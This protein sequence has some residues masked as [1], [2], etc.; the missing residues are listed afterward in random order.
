MTESE[1]K[2]GD[3]VIMY[4]NG[5]PIRGR[6]VKR[7]MKRFI[8]LND[9]SKWDLAGHPYPMMAWSTKMIRPATPERV[10]ELKRR[11]VVARIAGM[12]FKEWDALS[13]DQLDR[14]NSILKESS[15][16]PNG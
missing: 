5:A 16:A 15:E 3:K 12:T 14:I 10:L 8:E 11:S 13:V 4:E 2:E 6:I 9:D 7:V 1:F